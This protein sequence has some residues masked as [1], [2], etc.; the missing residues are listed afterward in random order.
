MAG[1]ASCV[2]SKMHSHDKIS[3]SISAMG[4]TFKPVLSRM[5]IGPGR[6][7]KVYAPHPESPHSLSRVN[8]NF[9]WAHHDLCLFHQ[10]IYF[11]LNERDKALEAYSTE[12]RPEFERHNRENLDYEWEAIQLSRVREYT[13]VHWMETTSIQAYG[14][15][16]LVVACWAMVEQYYGRVLIPTEMELG[17]PANRIEAPHKWHDLVKRFKGIGLDLLTCENYAGIDECRLVNNKIKHVGLVDKDLAKRTAF[18]GMEGKP[19]DQVTMPLQTY[20]DAV[21]EF[22]GCTMEKAGDLL[23]AKGITYETSQMKP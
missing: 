13:N 9:G 1:Q 19:F 17:G 4:D 18:T 2:N 20:V 23:I 6:G 10:A 3:H 8:S 21:F 12:M 14:D 5:Q 7:P 22:V 11:Q 16:L 15:Q